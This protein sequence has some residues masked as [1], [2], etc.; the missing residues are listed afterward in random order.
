MVRLCVEIFKVK[1]LFLCPNVE[2]SHLKILFQSQHTSELEHIFK[3]KYDLRIWFILLLLSK[4]SSHVLQEFQSLKE[5]VLFPS[6]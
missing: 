2:L 1:Q 6:C 4:P 3:G 5:L